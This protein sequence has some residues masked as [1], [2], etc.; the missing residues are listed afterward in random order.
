M[1]QTTQGLA[2]LWAVRGSNC[3]AGKKYSLF[4]TRSGTQAA[5]FTM[6]V[7]FLS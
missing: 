5:S 4:H 7:G 3:S 6:L 1:G 2:T